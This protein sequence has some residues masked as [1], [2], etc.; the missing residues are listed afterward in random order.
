[1]H[2]M[3]LFSQK[4]NRTRLAIELPLFRRYN[5]TS[6][7]ARLQHTNQMYFKHSTERRET[8]CE[9]FMCDDDLLTID[10]KHDDLLKYI[11]G[12]NAKFLGQTS[13]DRANCQTFIVY[14]R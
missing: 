13:L 9:W 7:S 12:L 4:F 11:F 8:E 10:N 2:E 14:S 1:M 3:S 6:I 5:N